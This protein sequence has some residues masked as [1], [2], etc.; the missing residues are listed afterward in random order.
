MGSDTS[1][2]GGAAAFSTRGRRNLTED[3]IELH[4]GPDDAAVHLVDGAGDVG[5]LLGR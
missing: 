1:T 5:S 3:E 4:V 2:T